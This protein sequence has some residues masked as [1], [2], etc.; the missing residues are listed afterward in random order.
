MECHSCFVW[1]FK[2]NL[3]L[4]EGAELTALETDVICLSAEEV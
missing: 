1:V 3:V 4:A 2:V